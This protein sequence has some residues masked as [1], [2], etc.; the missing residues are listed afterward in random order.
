[1]ALTS[2]PKDNPAGHRKPAWETTFLPRRDGTLIG[3]ELPACQ[4]WRQETR[5]WYELWRRHEIAPFLEPSDWSHLQSTALLV[6]LFWSE[7]V[8]PG[9]KVTLWAE[10]RRCQASYGATVQD[11][12]K[13]RMRFV[14]SEPQKGSEPPKKVDYSDLLD[15]LP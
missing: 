2:I 8:K 14:D 9:T 13:L 4:E 15:E 11:R 12:L 5:D 3:P 7:D 10:I 1:M 6:D